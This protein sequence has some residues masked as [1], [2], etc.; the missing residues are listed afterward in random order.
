MPTPRLT[1]RDL[2][3]CPDLACISAVLHDSERSHYPLTCPHARLLA[4]LPLYFCSVALLLHCCLN[5]VP[6]HHRQLTSCLLCE[7]TPQNKEM[8]T[9]TMG[10]STD[11]ISALSAR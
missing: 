8:C 10:G 5:A 2:F 7:K 6:I 9:S 1:A 4:Q 3:R 11:G